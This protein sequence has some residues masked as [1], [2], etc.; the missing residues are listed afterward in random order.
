[1]HLGGTSSWRPAGNCWT[2]L[3]SCA[4]SGG[5]KGCAQAHEKLGD[6]AGVRCGDGSAKRKSQYV[7]QGKLLL[8]SRSRGLRMAIRDSRVSRE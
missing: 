5:S 7:M 3:S 8:E 6:G 2:P 4:A 1:M